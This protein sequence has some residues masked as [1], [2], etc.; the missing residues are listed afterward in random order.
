VRKFKLLTILA[1]GLILPTSALAAKPEADAAVKKDAE[2]LQGNWTLA[3]AERRGEIAP[4]DFLKSVKL[5]FKGD[6]YTMTIDKEEKTGTFELRPSKNPKEIDLISDKQMS[7]AIYSLDKDKDKDTLKLVIDTE[8]KTRAKELS[9]PGKGSS[10]MLLVF[11]KA[12]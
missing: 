3:S 8:D 9:S 10:H 2:A 11:K 12:K 7:P 4:E 1:A 6:K 5:R